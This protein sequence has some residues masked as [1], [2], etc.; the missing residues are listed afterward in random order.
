MASASTTHDVRF[1]Q[2]AKVLVWQSGVLIGQ[3]P[4]ISVFGGQTAAIRPQIGSGLLVSTGSEGAAVRQHLKLSVASNI[5]FT[6]EADSA[7]VAARTSVRVV[8]RGPN[9]QDLSRPASLTTGQVFRQIEKTAQ[10][11]GTPDSQALELEITWT[12]SVRPALRI[13]TTG[14]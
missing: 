5:G 4:E 10:R 7:E 1:A 8:N 2:P 12:G 14:P 13:R 3:G 6:I 11:P 9:A